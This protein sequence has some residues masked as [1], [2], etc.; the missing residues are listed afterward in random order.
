MV[1]PEVL[2][3]SILC[4]FESLGIYSL[5][6]KNSLRKDAMTKGG[7]GRGMDLRISRTSKHNLNR[8]VDKRRRREGKEF[9]GD[10]VQ[11]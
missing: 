1:Q 5:N 7:W 9:I 2:R 10:V 3:T 4:G 11:K 8:K 6:M